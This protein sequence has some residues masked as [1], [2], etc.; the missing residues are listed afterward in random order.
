MK[1]EEL[2]DQAIDYIVSGINVDHLS[3]W[4][5]SF[6]ESVSDQWHRNRRLSDRQKEVL[7][8]IWDKQP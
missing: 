6:Y 7:G 8:N 1:Q 3:A 2:T 4:E 5:L